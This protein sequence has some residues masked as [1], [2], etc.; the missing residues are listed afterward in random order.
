MKRRDAVK[1][2]AA[3]CEGVTTDSRLRA[4]TVGRYYH[5]LPR[6][7]TEDSEQR[8]ELVAAPCSHRKDL[9]IMGRP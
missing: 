9:P 3:N 4:G 5:G 6:P 2:E 7:S 8:E 1:M